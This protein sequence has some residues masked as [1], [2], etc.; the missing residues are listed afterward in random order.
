MGYRLSKEEGDR[1][2][3]CWAGKGLVFAPV[4]MEGE[5]CFADTDVIRYSRVT[6]LSQVEWG[7]KS[8]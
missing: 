2:A 7:K 6:S 5:G 8:D 4:R 1:L 3:G